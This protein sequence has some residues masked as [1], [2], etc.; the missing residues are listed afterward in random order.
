MKDQIVRAPPCVRFWKT[1]RTAA[2][3]CR[4]WRTQKADEQLRGIRPRTSALAAGGLG[5]MA[6][7]A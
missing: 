2:N 6:A 3:C 5:R 7:A 1:R 4:C